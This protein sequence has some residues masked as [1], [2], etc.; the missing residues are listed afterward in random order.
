MSCDCQHKD[1]CAPVVHT[2]GDE[3]LV[4]IFDDL[5]NTFTKCYRHDNHISSGDEPLPCCSEAFRCAMKDGQTREEHCKT[6]KG[7]DDKSDRSAQHRGNHASGHTTA[8]C[9]PECYRSCGRFPWVC[10]AVTAKTG[11]YHKVK[12]HQYT[13]NGSLIHHQN[14]CDHGEHSQE[15]HQ[16]GQQ[17]EHGNK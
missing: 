10:V 8:R 3:E 17:L 5:E 2:E 13:S 1:C 16:H 4:H 12:P 11:N 7:K 14:K 15:S 6:T 9:H